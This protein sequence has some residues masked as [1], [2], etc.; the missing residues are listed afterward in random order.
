[1]SIA[2]S[3]QCVI[4]RLHREAARCTSSA[5]GDRSAVLAS[6]EPISVDVHRFGELLHVDLAHGVRE[7]VE[8]GE[9]QRRR[10]LLPEPSPGEFATVLAAC[11]SWIGRFRSSIASWIALSVRVA[12]AASTSTMSYSLTHARSSRTFALIVSG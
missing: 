7:R 12:T 1:V 9:V 5:R 10:F 2:A 8:G 6:R 3:T 4:P 11:R